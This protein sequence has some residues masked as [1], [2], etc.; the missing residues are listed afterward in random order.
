MSEPQVKIFLSLTRDGRLVRVDQTVATQPVML[1]IL[2]ASGTD[3]RVHVSARQVGVVSEE[4][5]LQKTMEGLLL[6]DPNQ[7]EPAREGGA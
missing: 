1:V 2:N 7:P 4:I 5:I 3:G 6:A